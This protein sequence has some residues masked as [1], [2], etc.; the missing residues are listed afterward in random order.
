MSI[1]ISILIVDKCLQADIFIKILNPQVKEIMSSFEFNKVFAA[2]LVAGLTAMLS[3]FI[4]DVLVHP[5]ELKEDAVAIEGGVVESA[6]AVEK[7]AEPILH[8]I[9]SADVARGEKLSKA[10]AACHSFDNGGPNKVGPNLWGVVGA[11]KANHSGFE[12]SSTLAGM[13]GSWGY[14][15]LNQFLWKPKKYAP[16]TKMNYNGIKDPED[17]AAMIA[18]LRTLGSS[19]ALPSQSE[20][21]AELALLAPPEPEEGEGNETEGDAPEAEAQ[22]EE[23]AASVQ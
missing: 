2:I 10:C 17:R 15:E 11:Q 13:D 19:K 5:K 12:Y 1:S 9:A 7:K 21:D 4:A 20:I 6:G 23:A 22:A 3:G 8:L 16:G 18:W 14:L